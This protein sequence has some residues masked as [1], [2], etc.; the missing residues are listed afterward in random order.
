MLLREHRLH[1]LPEREAARLRARA[2]LSSLPFPH[3]LPPFNL[4]LEIGEPGRVTEPFG[5]RVAVDLQLG[6][7][8]RRKQREREKE[9]AEENG[10]REARSGGGEGREGLRHRGATT[11][12]GK[13][14]AARSIDRPSQRLVKLEKKVGKT[15]RVFA[16][17]SLGGSAT[18]RTGGFGQVSP[19][20]RIGGHDDEI[21]PSLGKRTERTR[22]KRRRM[23]G[24]REGGRG[25]RRRERER[26]R[27]DVEWVVQL[28][29]GFALRSSTCSLVIRLFRSKPRLS[30]AKPG[31]GSVLV[32]IP[33]TSLAKHLAHLRRRHR[34]PS[35]R[36]ATYLLA[37]SLVPLPSPA[38]FVL[39]SRLLCLSLL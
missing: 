11:R 20:R 12:I 5:E 27:V 36:L 28:P 2:C 21:L 16:S 7:L 34:R 19:A 9:M 38:L 30:R 14:G 33:L 4:P 3:P 15:P 22:E 10:R 23:E 18:H 39:R 35:R 29:Y 13:R 1:R 24:G 26:E 6:D 37:R 31:A 25:G 32:T 8:K 17:E